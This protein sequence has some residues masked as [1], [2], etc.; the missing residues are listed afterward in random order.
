[1]EQIPREVRILRKGT[2]SSFSVCSLGAV[3]PTRLLHV[4]RGQRCALGTNNLPPSGPQ[5]S[6]ATPHTPFLFPVSGLFSLAGY[7]ALPELAANCASV[8]CCILSIYMDQD[9]VWERAQCS[10]QMGVICSQA[11]NTAYWKNIN[12]VI[13][14]KYE[15]STENDKKNLKIC[16]LEL[17]KRKILKNKTNPKSETH[18]PPPPPPPPAELRDR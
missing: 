2:D 17:L 9:S 15:Q 10:H 8:C 16:P 5:P 11:E 3:L 6:C 18:T 1:M 13:E 14:S 7:L 12:E 4:Q